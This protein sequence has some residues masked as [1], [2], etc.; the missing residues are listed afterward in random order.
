MKRQLRFS[1]VA[2]AVLLTVLATA[3]VY[4]AEPAIKAY[5]PPKHIRIPRPESEDPPGRAELED[6]VRR[7]ID[8]LCEIQYKS[9]CW[10][11]PQQT[12]GFDIYAPVPGA[13]HGFRAAVTSL[14]LSAL[15]QS[16]DTREKV[17]RAIDRG[18]DWMLVHLQNVRRADGVAIYNIWAHAYS[19]QALLLLQQRA[20]E[21]TQKIHK[22]GE[23]V[24]QQIDLLDRYESVDGGWGYY[25]FNAQTKQPSSK[26]TS[27]SAATCVIE[28]LRARENGYDVP[29]R[30][31]ARAVVSIKKQRKPDFSYL[32][33][34]HHW[35]KPLYSINRPGGSLGRSQVCNLALR[36]AGDKEVT[37][38]VLIDWLDRLFARNLWLDIGRKRPIPHESY[39]AVA[40][41]FFYYGHYYAAECIH[42]L[43]TK[44]RPRYQ[45]LLANLLINLQ[46]KDGS[47]WDFPLY[48][49]HQPYGTAFAVMSLLRCRP[50]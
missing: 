9:G 48:N 6:S 30:S 14:V 39:F 32:Y 16:G 29:E 13:H 5:R 43:P 50:S 24:R 38:Q 12:K 31:T 19:I 46:E 49:Y 47:W 28:L 45:A 26:V 44:E 4:G 17:S 34:A 10:G 37:D 25:D 18:E 41:Y 3:S 2:L 22:L 33:G 11:G 1:I 42:E 23:L 15:I 20:A 21:D 40:G 35:H 27:F 36:R 8:F 7:G